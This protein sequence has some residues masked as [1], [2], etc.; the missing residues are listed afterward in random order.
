MHSDIAVRWN[1]SMV[2]PK[3]LAVE[4]HMFDEIAS[5]AA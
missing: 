2:N 5:F 4:I 3:F 1:T